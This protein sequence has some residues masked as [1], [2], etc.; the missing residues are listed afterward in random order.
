M[1]FLDHRLVEFSE[2]IPPQYKLHGLTEKY[3]LRQAVKGLVPK[4]TLNRKKQRFY[5]PIDRWLE[6]DLSSLKE[7]LLSKREIEKSSA[8][9]FSHIEKM[10]ER[11]KS[12]PLFYARQ[13]WVALTYQIWHKQFIQGQKIGKY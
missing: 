6:N 7:N 13:L 9:N 12:A 5:V 3:L 8:F 2:R 11:Y 10:Q 4:A 1:S